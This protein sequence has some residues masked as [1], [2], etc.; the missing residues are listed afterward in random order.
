MMD[1]R[2]TLAR[3]SAGTATIE[4]ALLAPVLA[5]MLI[6]LIDIGSS[7]S[8]KLRLE[9]VAQRTI[10]KVQATTFTVTMQTA[11]ETE[12]ETA[13]GAG[14]DATLT[15]W[16]ECDGTKMTGSSAYTAGCANGQAY[17]RYVQLAIEK[18]ISPLIVG[19]FFSNVNSDGTVTVHGKAGIRIQ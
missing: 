10:E 14:S 13:A 17:A 8:D 18:D 5:A 6:G 12:A 9:Q 1:Q 3:D 2:L 16:L 4:L 7:Y 15:Y 11:L 19:P